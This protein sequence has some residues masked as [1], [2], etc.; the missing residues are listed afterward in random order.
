MWR[1][2]DDTDSILIPG[3]L[4]DENDKTIGVS[5]YTRNYPPS[6]FNLRLIRAS[7]TL[8]HHLLTIP[9]EERSTEAQI[10]L[11]WIQGEIL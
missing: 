4:V 2:T 3:L 6:Q 7:E 10:L 5:I 1:W 9:E 11:S 8:Y